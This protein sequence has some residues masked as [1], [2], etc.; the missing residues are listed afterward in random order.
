[1]GLHHCGVDLR[2]GTAVTRYSNGATSRGVGPTVKCPN[3]ACKEKGQRDKPRPCPRCGVAWMPWCQNLTEEGERCD[4][5]RWPYVDAEN[6]PPMHPD[7]RGE[8]VDPDVE[9]TPL[10]RRAEQRARGKMGRTNPHAVLKE[11]AGAAWVAA[12]G[13]DAERLKLIDGASKVAE[14]AA[15]DDVAAA[16]MTTGEQTDHVTVVFHRVGNEPD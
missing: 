13:G 1:M 16:A 9:L 8:E 2:F 4:L 5:H 7:W 12:L 15:K 10:H 14:R 6:P 3:P 11:Q